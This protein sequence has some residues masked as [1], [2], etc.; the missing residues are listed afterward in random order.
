MQT[1]YK[2]PLE[3]K[4]AVVTGAGRGM[5]PITPHLLLLSVQVGC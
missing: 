5:L 2:A 3:G 1:H 4:V